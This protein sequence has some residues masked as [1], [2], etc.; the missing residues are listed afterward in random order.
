MIV[1]LSVIFLSFI[2]LGLPDTIIGSIWPTIQKDTLSY[3]YGAGVITL[4]IQCGT[5]I[6]SLYSSKLVYKYSTRI[7]TFFSIILTSIALIL[8]SLSYNLFF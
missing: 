6:S 4:I 3:V 2:G 1:L 8:F 5:V 7:V